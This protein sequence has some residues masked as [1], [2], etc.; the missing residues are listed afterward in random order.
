MALFALLCVVL[1]VMSYIATIV[2]VLL[3][4]PDAAWSA[5][6][7]RALVTLIDVFVL[8]VLAHG[9]AALFKRQ[10]GWIPPP[11]EAAASGHFAR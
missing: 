4:L 7:L 11:L 9:L 6:L 3:Q 1:G 5:A 8:Y 10:T 2:F